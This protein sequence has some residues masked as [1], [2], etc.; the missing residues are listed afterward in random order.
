MPD[1]VAVFVETGSDVRGGL[2]CA[3]ERV[4]QEKAFHAMTIYSTSTLRLSN[5][6]MKNRNRGP[7]VI[8]KPRSIPK[9]ISETDADSIAKTKKPDFRKSRMEQ[10][11]YR[12]FGAVLLKGIEF[13]NNAYSIIIDYLALL[14]PME[15]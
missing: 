11:F 13:I 3:I 7:A 1:R 2:F 4:L 9:N 10:P 8:P 12:A 6:I 5:L 14:C 15:K